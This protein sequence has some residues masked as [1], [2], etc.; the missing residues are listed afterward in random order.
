[1]TMWRR[2]VPPIQ[3]TNPESQIAFSCLC[4]SL[5]ISQSSCVFHGL[6]TFQEYWSIIFAELPS[7]WVFQ[8]F[9]HE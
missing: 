1:M 4:L 8:I 2:A 6:D 9:F 3:L 7:I 5:T